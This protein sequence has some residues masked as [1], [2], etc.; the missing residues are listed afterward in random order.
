MN[1]TQAVKDKARELG[2][3][4]VGVAP[5]ERFK[6]APLRM[7][8]LGLLPSAKCAV[9][10]AVHHLD[11]AVELGGEPSSQ[12]IGPYATQYVMNARLDD[13]S[14]GLARFLEAKGFVAL[15]IAASN[16]WRYHGWKE[17]K[18]DFAPDLA[19]RYAAVAAGLGEI[20]WN[21]LAMTPE[22][23]PRA[24]FVTVLTDAA[25]VPTPMYDGPPLCDR[26]MEC[27]KHCPTDAFRKE[28]RGMAKVEIGGRAFTFPQ[29]NKWR[30]SWGENFDL[31]LALPIPDKIDESV[32]LA[33]LEK[34]GMRGG[35]MGS[36]LRFCMTP[37]R[38]Y[39]DRAYSRA[40]RRKK[41]RTER[42]PAKLLAKVLGLF[43]KSPLDV[44]AVGRASDFR[45]HAAVH[46][47]YHLPDAQTVISIAVAPPAG[48]ESTPLASALVRRALDYAAFEIARALDVAGYDAVTMTK[49]AD[50]LVAQRLG[51]YRGE[52]QFA[53][54]LTSAKLPTAV[55]RKGARKA[56]P[57]AKAVKRLATAAGADLVGIFDAARFEK[58]RA[59]VGATHAS[60]LL[61][62]P[63]EGVV[64]RGLI[65]GPYVPQIVRENARM[66]GP[67]DRLAGA[68][69]VVVLGMHFPHASLDTVGVTPAE[70]NGPF[71]F[72][73]YEALF[74]LRD[75]ALRVAK[76][77][78]A[79]GARATIVD[80][81]TGLA[82]TVKTSRG[83]IPDLRASADAAALAGLAQIGVH[84]YPITPEFGV[85]QRFVAV[86]TDLALA[87]DA[88]PE[89][90]RPC[91]TCDRRCAKACPTAA[92]GSTKKSLRLDGRTLRCA[93]VDGFACDWA[94]RYAL[95]GADGTACWG[96]DSDRPL[97]KRRT[98][99]SVAAAVADVKWGIQ[100]RHI[101]VA[102]ECL[103]VCPARGKSMERKR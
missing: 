98:A 83:Q 67:E 66:L 22:F 78:S 72:A 57:S 54:V 96:V 101:N 26:C 92:I 74:L 80:D 35:E 46:P 4:L 97:P 7:S 85:R 51:V 11:A 2:A 38:R 42:S 40:P 41:E 48:S 32:A 50:N 79:S 95:S 60:P 103:R 17:M 39:Y 93:A 37:K 21:N 62:R 24:R 77:L 10:M 99:E 49:I 65:Y 25:L 9:V 55:R 59:A 29:T 18:V 91:E 86:V 5:V 44:I 100:K 82:S 70:T 88:L 13:L 19:H 58:F 87:S 23:G 3:D 20:G 30:C 45:G 69:S 61:S 53:T 81:L 31:D 34:H 94:K 28:V 36:C 14:F 16:I 90:A 102:G 47:A 76:A 64:D 15:P 73:Q 43:R 1:L 52:A 27:V 12:D 56:K 63:A 8:P 68:K 6:N 89:F 33:A 84:G 75:A 71:A